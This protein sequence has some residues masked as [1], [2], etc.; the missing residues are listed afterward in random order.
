LLQDRYH[1]EYYGLR[2]GVLLVLNVRQDLW[3]RYLLLKSE[4]VEKSMGQPK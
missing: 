3:Q 1:T 2:P 4:K